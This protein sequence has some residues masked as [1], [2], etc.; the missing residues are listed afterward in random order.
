VDQTRLI[1]RSL[2]D[3]VAGVEEAPT[4]D[5]EQTTEI[6]TRNGA[7][8]CLDHGKNG[9]TSKN[10]LANGFPWNKTGSEPFTARKAR[11]QKVLSRKSG[12]TLQSV[13]IF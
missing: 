2:M 6:I 5:H 10:R 8:F 7:E 3:G 9:E 4:P 12:P 13:R 1:G 11:I